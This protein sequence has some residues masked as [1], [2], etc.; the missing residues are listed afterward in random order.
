[1][2]FYVESQQSDIF[3]FLSYDYIAVAVNLKLAI[4]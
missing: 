2:T 4:V 1:M 3:L